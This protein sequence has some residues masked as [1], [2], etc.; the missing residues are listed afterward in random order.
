MENQI[1]NDENN[2]QV[3]AKK[4]WIKPEMKKMEIFGGGTGILESATASPKS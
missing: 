4:T 3:V 2:E 1:P